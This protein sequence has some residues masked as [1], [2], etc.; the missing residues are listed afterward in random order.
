M[1]LQ[2]EL[3]NDLPEKIQAAVPDGKNV[4][5]MGVFAFIDSSGKH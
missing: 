3:L 4:Y 5:I 1:F 2:A